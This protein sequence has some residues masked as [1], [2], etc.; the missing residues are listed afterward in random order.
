MA[1]EFLKEDIAK[2]ILQVRVEKNEA[3]RSVEKK[4]EEIGWVAWASGWGAQLASLLLARG[5]AH[6]YLLV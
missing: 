6:C 3:A 4:V 2:S 1:G 5:F